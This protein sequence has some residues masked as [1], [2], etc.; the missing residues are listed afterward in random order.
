MAE[1]PLSGNPAL[2]PELCRAARALLGWAGDELAER[3]RVGVEWLRGF[4]EGREP[5]DGAREGTVEG[6]SERERL[7]R[8]L[9]AAGIDFLAPG[10]P[11][12]GGGPGLRIKQA[13]GYI[14]AERLSS[15][16]DV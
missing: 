16:N 15:A 8:T 2:S 11:S 10:E 5:S 7:R 6:E 1:T 13:G 9:E 4:E 14:P 3:A 12:S